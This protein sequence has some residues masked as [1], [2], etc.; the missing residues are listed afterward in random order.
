M[1]EHRVCSTDTVGAIRSTNS[2][3][4]IR[5]DDTSQT[6]T[7]EPGERPVQLQAHLGLVGQ[8]ERARGPLDLAS[9]GEEPTEA[10]RSQRHG[11]GRYCEL[12]T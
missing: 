2:G 6:P 12:C 3:G 4:S 1:A 10:V 7:A 9:P 5:S 8:H 11:K